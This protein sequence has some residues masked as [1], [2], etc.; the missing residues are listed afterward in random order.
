MKKKLLITM[1]PGVF[2]VTPS[3]ASR[4]TGLTAFATKTRMARRN[5]ASAARRQRAFLRRLQAID[6]MTSGGV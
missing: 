6:S 1:V 4:G 2:P 5:T 3:I